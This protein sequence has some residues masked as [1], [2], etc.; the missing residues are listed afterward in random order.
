[1]IE[2]LKLYFNK[3]NKFERASVNIEKY[4]KI[5]N[6]LSSN[7]LTD[8]QKFEA[9]RNDVWNKWDYE[10]QII[11]YEEWQEYVGSGAIDDHWSINIATN[12]RFNKKLI[13]YTEIK[14]NQNPYELVG[15]LTFDKSGHMTFITN[16]VLVNNKPLLVCAVLTK[17]PNKLLQDGLAFDLGVVVGELIINNIG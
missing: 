14:K 7:N 17:N 8:N 6:K 2:F 16:I 3:I 9:F 12:L 4:S 5:K 15:F 1:M 10:Q 11:F 13:L